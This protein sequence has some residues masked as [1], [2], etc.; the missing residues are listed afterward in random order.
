[1][2]GLF[3]GIPIEFHQAA[4]YSDTVKALWPN[5]D[6]ITW[7]E[8]EYMHITLAYVNT[9]DIRDYRVVL[10]IIQAM[11]EVTERICMN[12]KHFD[13]GLDQFEWFGPSHEVLVTTTQ[14][15]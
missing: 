9:R 7:F 15:R 2:K 10:N 6:Y 13:I 4:E 8:P 12:Y 5:H 1:M 3:I 11:R 14:P